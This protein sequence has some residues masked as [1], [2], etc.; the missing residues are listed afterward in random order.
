MSDEIGDVAGKSDD[1]TDDGE[2]KLA[3]FVVAAILAAEKVVSLNTL[4]N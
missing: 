2:H 1:A 4:I 3:R